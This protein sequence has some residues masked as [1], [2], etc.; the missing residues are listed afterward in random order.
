MSVG[1]DHEHSQRQVLAFVQAMRERL[2][3]RSWKRAA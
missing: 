1:V 2:P 3:D